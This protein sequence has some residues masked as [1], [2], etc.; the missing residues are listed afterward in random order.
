MGDMSDNLTSLNLGYVEE[1]Y[2]AWCENPAAV[3]E[4][5]QQFFASSREGAAEGASASNGQ[6]SRP[7]LDRQG[8]FEARA[9]GFEPQLPVRG[10]G[11]PTVP[12]AEP[13]AP[14]PGA[15]SEPTNGHPHPASNGNGHAAIT[16]RPTSERYT[17]VQRGTGTEALSDLQ[18][19]VDQL[20]R[21]IRV[22]GH[23]I[24]QLD[25]LGLPREAPP[26]LDPA[27]Y[28]LTDQDM[29]RVFTM[30]SS[31]RNRRALSLRQ[32]IELLQNTYCRHIGVQYMH[33]DDLEMREWLQERMEG[34][35]NR[36]YLDRPNQLRILTRLTDAVIFEQFVQKKY[37]GAKTFS[38]EGGESLIPLLE[39]AIEKAGGQGVREIVM[40]MAHRGR[41][42]VLA[43]ILGK[44]AKQIFREFE[45]ADAGDLL[46]RGDVKYHKGHSSD[47]HTARGEKVHLSLCFNPSHLE[48]INPVALGRMRA[49][50]DRGGAGWR[51][52]GL[53]IQ[54]H[55][56]AAFAGEGIVQ[57]TLNLSQLEGYDTGGALHI[58]VNNQIGFTTSPEQGRST[59]YATSVAKML[60]SPVFHV[61]GEDP[62]AVAQALELSLDFRR[63]FGRDAFIDMYCYRRRGHN[64]GD[65]PSF[66]QPLLYQA[67]QKRKGV[68]DGYLEHLLKLGGVTAD[69][70]AI[71][72][73]QRLEHLEAELA[74]AREQWTPPVSKRTRSVWNDY[75]GGPDHAVQEVDTA[76]PQ[77]QLAHLLQKLSRV[78]RDFHAHPKILRLLE[79]RKEMV[80]GERR[81][82]WAAG[83]A[84]ALASLATGGWR[85]RMSG[86]DCERGTFSHRHA[87]LHDV[88]T[89]RRW[90]PFAHLSDSQAAVEFFNSPLSEAGVLGFEYGYSLDRPDGLVIWE[91]QFGD[92]INAAQVIVD[93]F[94]ASGEEKWNRLSGLVVLLPHG[95]EGQGP[96]H[97]SGRLERLLLLSASDN[98]QV[99]YPTTPAQ[100]FHLL[101]RQ[102]LRPWRKPLFVMTPKSMLRLPA[103]TSQLAD[104]EGRFQR[105]L[106]DTVEDRTK[107]V[108]RVLLCTGKLYYELDEYRQKQGLQA[109]VAI[110]RMEQ[111][112]PLSQAALEAALE[113]YPPET[114]MVWVQEE[115]E[116]MGAWR[117]MKIRFGDLI[118]QRGP[119]RFRGVMR[120]AAAS[121]ATGSAKAHRIEQ[122]RILEEA[123][124]LPAG[125]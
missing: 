8:F 9:L 63:Q 68:R 125:H 24:A 70:A 83:E 81:L 67:I 118:D 104:F 38:L 44:S 97:S 100:F 59:L 113:P 41:L 111:L 96:E 124:D 90:S 75:V 110:L 58:I 40:G 20:I 10:A 31:R 30:S 32:I 60:A 26:E 106:P 53:A 109:D 108:R 29:D 54:I 94:I 33:I 23:R 13:A 78:P 123:F 72:E 51:Q 65:E 71:I 21:N 80:V 47:W 16:I 102:V 116:N 114:E 89:G 69:E 15:A 61:N 35:E 48:F 120:P 14:S 92:F 27:F 62:E 57:E 98:M 17:A 73:A 18:H 105:I 46:G 122:D 36:I 107:P 77:A 43:N 95:F 74:A 6:K 37:L 19:R 85:I 52:K 49:K 82:D 55:G 88:Q 2:D 56:D 93:Q 117:Y 7:H 4:H 76:M 91:A 119:H 79:A 103:A 11:R 66:T 1:L 25:P 115:P 87:V 121:P 99:S 112:Y 3:P 101:R 45:D 42:N 64:E 50:M 28:G 84:L 12:A 22:R 34:S 39:M 86:Q 5:W